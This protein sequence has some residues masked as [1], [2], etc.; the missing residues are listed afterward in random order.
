MLMVKNVL[1]RNEC[2]TL[3]YGMIPHLMS[4]MN[5]NFKKQKNKIRLPPIQI[6]HNLGQL[7]LVHSWVQ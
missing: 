3:R 2:F 5:S 1:L 6:P 7:S 4:K